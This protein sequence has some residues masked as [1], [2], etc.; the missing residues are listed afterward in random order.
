MVTSLSGIMRLEKDVTISHDL[1]LSWKDSYMV[2]FMSVCAKPTF[3]T[4]GCRTRRGA[5]IRHARTSA[6]RVAQVDG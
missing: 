2:K 1:L 5:G 6:R 4:S 3:I